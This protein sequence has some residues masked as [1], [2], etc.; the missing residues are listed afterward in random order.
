MRVSTPGVCKTGRFGNQFRR[1]ETLE[2]HPAPLVAPACWD[3]F[4]YRFPKYSF[5]IRSRAAHVRL[6]RKEGSPRR[7]RREHL[8]ERV[9][10]RAETEPNESA[11]AVKRAGDGR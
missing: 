10:R 7:R 2:L 4:Q 5:V 9:S 11:Q 1:Q 3:R 8:L 6:A